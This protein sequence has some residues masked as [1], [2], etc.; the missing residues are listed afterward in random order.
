MM[1]GADDSLLVVATS[2]MAAPVAIGGPT[3]IHG[4]EGSDT[5]ILP[6][7]GIS[8]NSGITSS[9]SALRRTRDLRA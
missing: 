5:A 8:A 2:S 9:P 7:G 1:A 6:S 4:E 3:D